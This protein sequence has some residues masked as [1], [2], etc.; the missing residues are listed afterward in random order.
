MSTSN[1]NIRKAENGFVL[2]QWVNNTDNCYIFHKWEELISWL[3]V[4]PLPIT[5]VTA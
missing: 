4:H 3:D 2:D 5:I 1:Y